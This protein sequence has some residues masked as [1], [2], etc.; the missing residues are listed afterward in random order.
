VAVTPFVFTGSWS[1]VSGAAPLSSASSTKYL[2]G[3]DGVQYT[4]Q[5]ASGATS[6]N[7]PFTYKSDATSDTAGTVSSCVN[8]A[9]CQLSAFSGLS[10]TFKAGQT[11]AAGSTYLIDVGVQ[12]SSLVS[13]DTAV[14]TVVPVAGTTSPS[15][16]LVG[17]GYTLSAGTSGGYGSATEFVDAAVGTGMGSYTV[18]PGITLTPDASS[19][20]GTYIGDV[21]YSI[22]QGP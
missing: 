6:T 21:Q 5:V 14:G 12:S 20:A 4:V 3:E 11:Y 7:T 13:L 16:A 1:P 17:S 10:V 9:A 22:V 18:I 15:P 8:G 2:G 19:W